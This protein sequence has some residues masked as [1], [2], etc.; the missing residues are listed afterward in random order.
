M[1]VFEIRVNVEIRSKLKKV[2]VEIRLKKWEESEC[3]CDINNYT[4]NSE[5][6]KE[7]E[8]LTWYSVHLWRTNHR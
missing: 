2:N 5:W 4:S 7:R 8:M 1:C 3:V 6:L